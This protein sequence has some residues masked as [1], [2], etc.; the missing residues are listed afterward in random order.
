MFCL[1]KPTVANFNNGIQSLDL[2][3][4]F[5]GPTILNSLSF[6]AHTFQVFYYQL[7]KHLYYSMRLT[8]CQDGAL[9]SKAKLTQTTNLCEL[10][11]SQGTRRK[12]T[13]NAA[14]SWRNSF[15]HSGSWTRNRGMIISHFGTQGRS[16][17]GTQEPF[18]GISHALLI[19]APIRP[20][21][22]RR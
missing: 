20:N 22:Y 11:D 15:S 14:I 19:Y 4:S 3:L 17:E 12:R 2:T 13:R 6:K 5:Q 18:I 21:R 16:K 10:K 1:C 7:P 9:M 8:I